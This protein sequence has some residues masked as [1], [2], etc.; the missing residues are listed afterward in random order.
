MPLSSQSRGRK[1]LLVCAAGFHLTLTACLNRALARYR[2]Y[3][4][5][6]RVLGSD[7][8]DNT[9]SRSGHP[10]SLGESEA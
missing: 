7:F 5:T 8:N 3:R 9:I 6:A 1:P 10:G 4:V 2:A